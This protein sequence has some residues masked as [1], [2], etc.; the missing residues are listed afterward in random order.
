MHVMKGADDGL[1]GC[2]LGSFFF[3]DAMNLI[4]MAVERARRRVTNMSP[5]K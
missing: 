2:F 5:S 3:G 1:Y 4:M